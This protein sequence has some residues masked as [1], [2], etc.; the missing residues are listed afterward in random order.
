MQRTSVATRPRTPEQQPQPTISLRPTPRC[1]P[2]FDDELEPSFW[3]TA[4]QLSLDW[5]PRRPAP[6]GP[7][8]DAPRHSPAAGV[9]PDAKLAVKRFVRTCVEVID[10]HR[11][12]A[13][14]R[15]LSH[16][17]QAAGVVAQGTAAAHR[18]RELRETMKRPRRR[19]A[20]RRAGDRPTPVA[21]LHVRL[22][23]PRPG[24]V[25]A[26][27]ALLTAERTCA[28]ALR[29]ELHEAEWQ[30]TALRLL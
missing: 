28:M 3:A 21:V 25:E 14:L 18:V 4:H 22:C 10:G 23:E 9:S 11:P 17:M 15:R 29:L 27:V 2:P 13:H 16:P 30:A 7:A 24:A 5:S 12:A 1:E 19:A 6:P 26:A 8:A 20:G